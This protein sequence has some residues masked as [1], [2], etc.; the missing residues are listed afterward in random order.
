MVPKPVAKRNS[1]ALTGYCLISV[2]TWEKMKHTT[3][4][5]TYFSKSKVK[6]LNRIQMNNLKRVHPKLEFL[7]SVLLE[8]LVSGHTESLL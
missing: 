8:M 1:E 3:L 6:H 7:G 2:L 4:Q 5:N